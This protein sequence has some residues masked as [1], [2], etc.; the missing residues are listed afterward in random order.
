M[1]IQQ[2]K[3]LKILL[4]GDSCQDVY[5]YGRCSR[6]SPEAPI[7]IFEKDREETKEGMSANVCQNLSNLGCNVTHITNTN[8]IKKTRVVDDRFGQHIVRIDE[9][10]DKDELDLSYLKSCD[11]ILGADF[12]CV[13]ISDYDKGF[14]ASEKTLEIL[15]FIKDTWKDSCIFVDSKKKD[16][17][18]FGDNVIFKINNEEFKNINV[19][20]EKYE[21]VV[22]LGKLGATWN[23]KYYPAIKTDVYDVCGAGDTFLSALVWKYMTNNH[24][25][26]DAIIFANICASI[27]V[28]KIGAYAITIEDIKKLEKKY[29]K[30]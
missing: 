19:F 28:R 29:A 13:V 2:Q 25:M 24:S 9:I 11:E 23:G 27:T 3:L 26:E 18:C 5:I 21:C 12:D 30:E 17:S 6:L 1:D 16:L 8:I 4:I 20:P 15:S 22:T 7:P 14:L 10:A